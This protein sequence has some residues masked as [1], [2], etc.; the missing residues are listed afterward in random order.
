MTAEDEI[1]HLRER[2]DIRFSAKEEALN[3]ALYRL[4]ERLEERNELREQISKER[5]MYLSR[6]RFDAEHSTLTGRVSALELQNSKWAGSLW[7]LGAAVSAIV[8]LVNIA[9]KIWLK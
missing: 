6:E 4:N 1:R 2:V 3:L 8:V 5:G 7:M 9:M